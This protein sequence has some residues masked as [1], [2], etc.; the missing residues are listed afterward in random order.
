MSQKLIAA[1]ITSIIIA[2][3]LTL[4]IVRPLTLG[5]FFTKA[6]PSPEVLWLQ[7]Q[8]QRSLLQKEIIR[9]NRIISKAELDIQNIPRNDALKLYTFIGTMS[10]FG[11]LALILGVSYSTVL[12]EKGG[13]VFAKIN[14]N[15]QIPVRFRDIP[16]LYHLFYHIGLEQTGAENMEKAFKLNQAIVGEHTKLAR[17]FKQPAAQAVEGIASM[18]AIATSASYPSFADLYAQNAISNNGSGFV[19]GLN[20]QLEP[21][22][23]RPQDFKALAMGGRQ[24]SGKTLTL[25]YLLTCLIKYYD[26]KAFII[27]PHIHNQESLKQVMHPLEKIKKV[28]SYNEFEL[29][30]ALSTI[31]GH[32]TRRMS[33]E[34]SSERPIIFV[35]DELSRLFRN[36]KKKTDSSVFLQLITFLEQAT[37]ETRKTNII[38]IGGAHTW[39]SRQFKGLT[40]IR[41]S[42]NSCLLHQMKPNQAKFFF[43]QPQEQRMIKKIQ[44]PGDALMQIDFDTTPE[45][46]HVPLI[47]RSDIKGVAEELQPENDAPAPSCEAL[48]PNSKDIVELLKDKREKSTL[49]KMDWNKQLSNATGIST[50]V[51]N[52]VLTGHR[53]L[54]QE[55][56]KRCWALL[57]R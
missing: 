40:Y 16:Q 2:V 48:M 27:D 31:T 36:V 11:V 54:S 4:L 56:A 17:M 51:L 9:N 35:I 20:T 33:G 29:P 49:G 47:T 55:N 23:R 30:T 7:E 18:P 22:Y 14:E 1:S 57:N 39:D 50:S 5:A 43:D 28:K 52:S 8:Y 53:D 46:I 15:C 42:F 38:F 34:E 32:F 21:R 19:I 3:I 45:H 10:L 6:P 37:Q 12:R 44:T 41:D 24:G 26:A 13:T 25:A